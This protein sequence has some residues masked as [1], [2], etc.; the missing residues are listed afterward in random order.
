MIVNQ[1]KPI[2]LD[3]TTMKFPPMAIVSILH[4]LSGLALFI[5]MPAILYFFGASLK[6]P[7]SFQ[8]L[9]LMFK[10]TTYKIVLFLF[11]A[12]LIFHLFAGIRHLL[13]DIGYGEALH[14]GRHTAIFVMAMAA[15]F[16]ILLGIWIW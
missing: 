15:I 3:L 12:A 8:N 13:M 10:L 4:R 2:N 9:Q 1:K 14:S 6:S 5:L 11:C 16:I 7:Q